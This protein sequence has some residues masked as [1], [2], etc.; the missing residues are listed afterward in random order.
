MIK[1]PQERTLVIIKPD[2]I[3]RELAGEILSRFERKGLKII[4]IKMELLPIKTVKE[5]Y[6]YLAE[7]VFFDE[8]VRFMSSI[9]S[10][11]M[12]IEGKDAIAVVR[13]MC[14]VTNARQA[15][16]GTIRGDLG[17][18]AMSN[19]VHAS[20]NAQ[21]AQTEIKRF[22]SSSEIHDFEKISFETIYASDERG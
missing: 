11:L 8:L 21:A 2:A 15:G 20:E 9:P 22:F 17:M 16:V 6:A 19:L 5:H 13:Q 14:G 10:I 18:S 3:Q 7:R 12:V 4:A 1:M